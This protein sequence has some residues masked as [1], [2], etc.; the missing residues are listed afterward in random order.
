MLPEEPRE[1]RKFASRV[2]TRLPCGKE[3]IHLQERLGSNLDRR[4]RGV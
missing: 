3:E 2:P 1:K 4:Q